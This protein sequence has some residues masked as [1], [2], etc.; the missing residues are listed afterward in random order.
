MSVSFSS[1]RARGNAAL[2]LPFDWRP[3]YCQHAN[4][5]FSWDNISCGCL[6]SFFKKYNT[7]DGAKT[8]IVLRPDGE[9]SGAMRRR[10]QKS[11][12]RTAGS[13]ASR[14]WPIPRNAN[15]LNEWKSHGSKEIS[16]LSVAFP[17]SVVNISFPARQGYTTLAY[18]SWK[19]NTDGRRESLENGGQLSLSKTQRVHK[20]N[21]AE[22]AAA[23]IYMTQTAAAA[24]LERRL[25]CPFSWC[26]TGPRIYITL[27]PLSIWPDCYI[28]N[29]PLSRRTLGF[30][31][32]IL[33]CPSR[34]LYFGA[35]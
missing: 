8:T 32:A 12:G 5:Q 26:C 2:E 33:G 6:F 24:T 17:L 35:I 7:S 25:F 23:V 19:K 21:S 16:F 18:T 9:N 34:G 1:C 28:N 11:E 14:P 30:K 20:A 10:Q 31:V 15:K 27:H 29:P 13:S 4:L 3:R 22:A